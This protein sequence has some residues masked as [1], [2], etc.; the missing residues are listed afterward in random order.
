M[1]RVSLLCVL[2]SFSLLPLYSFPLHPGSTGSSPPGAQH[3]CLPGLPCRE[4]QPG[5][6]GEVMLPRTSL[7]SVPPQ[8][9]EATFPPPKSFLFPRP[10]PS[11]TFNA[12]GQSAT[13]QWLHRQG[14]FWIPS[15]GVEVG[16][17][18][19]QGRKSSAEDDSAC[20]VHYSG[21]E[22]IGQ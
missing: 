18:G 20:C 15:W 16:R 1:T 4:S 22:V 21:T 2:V 12:R 10:G 6:P 9:L 14:G 17:G 13:F 7:P 3:P 5:L 11:R 19:R 8:G